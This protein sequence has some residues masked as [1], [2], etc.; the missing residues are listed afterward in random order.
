VVLH[1]RDVPCRMVRKSNPQ[2]RHPLD[3]ADSGRTLH[4]D[5]ECRE[6][7][8][9]IQ[10]MRLHPDATLSH[11]VLVQPLASGGMGELWRAVDT[12]LDRE[13]AIKILPDDRASDRRWLAR[14]EQEARLVAALNHP[15]IVTIHSVESC[16]GIHFFTMEYIRGRRLSQM[17]PLE[18]FP[19]PEMLDLAIP[20]VRALSAVH[21]RGIVHGDLKPAN[22]MVSEQGHVK[23]LDFGLGRM[24]RVAAGAISEMST[25]SAVSEDGISGTLPYM[26]PEQIRGEVLDHRSD[27]FSVG[28]MLY[29]MATG[30][31]PFDGETGVAVGAAILRDE[32]EALSTRRP[33]LPLHLGWLI[34]RCLV[35]DASLRLQSSVH[36]QQELEALKVG[37][38]AVRTDEPTIAV[39]PFVD[40]SQE[41]DQEYLCEGLAEEI[42]SALTRVKNLHVSSRGSSFQFKGLS[43]APREIGRRLG[44][45]TLLEGSVRKSGDRVRVTAQ[46][47]NVAD[48]YCLW[49]ER[50]ERRLQDIFAIQEEIARSIVEALGVT[51]TPQEQRAVGRAGTDDIDA[52]DCYLRGISFLNQYTR[53]SIEFARQMFT[54]AIEIDPQFALGHAGLSD[55][56]SFLYTYVR[57]DESLLAEAEAASR[58]ALD[59]DPG[60]AHAHASLASTLSLC[61][62]IEEADAEFERAIA[63]GPRRFEPHFY[64]ARHCFLQGRFEDAARMFQRAAE[65]EPE[66][67]QARLLLA[68]V[69][70][71]LG[72]TD[73]AEAMRRRGANIARDRLQRN[74]DDIRALYLLANALLRLGERAR[75]LEYTER[76]IELGQDDAM[77]F[78]NVGCIFAIAGEQDRALEFLER[79][80]RAGNI[81]VAWFRNDPDLDAIR[82]TLRFQQLLE[83]LEVLQGGPPDAGG[84]AAEDGGEHVA[85]DRAPKKT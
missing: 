74:P 15:N 80:A 60:L 40:M 70:A 12:K 9:E 52:Y 5:R 42:I 76:A 63:L 25:A 4:W 33:E 66:D 31:R 16:D 46:L 50:F 41:R 1:R 69:Y 37:A 56:A 84:N 20:I 64:Y 27:L 62:R 44:V 7:G 13:V 58:R 22:V 14:F 67:Y 39:L 19:L 3:S 75:A 2:S 11:Y 18:G 72:R 55:C 26:S 83:W 78:Y 29:E 35:K 65:L 47:T 77:L 81:G 82:G 85:G 68:G 6:A 61:D 73:D 21:E 24:V 8:D 57:R 53:R 36:L 23:V 38:L 30:R 10:A 28:I 43:L 32:P 51:L 49:S 17:I 34:E 54:R 79:A 48:S 45:R 59:I 71:R